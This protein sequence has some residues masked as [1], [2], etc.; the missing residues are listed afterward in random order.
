M[1]KENH[2]QEL[3]SKHGQGVIDPEHIES[4]LSRLGKGP[5]SRI[6][7]E[8]SGLGLSY[9]QKR[10]TK[11]EKKISEKQSLRYDEIQWYRQEALKK[12]EKAQ[13][14]ESDKSRRDKEIWESDQML[15]RL[16][17]PLIEIGFANSEQSATRII[18]MI[19]DS[20]FYQ[21]TIQ[22]FRLF[23]KLLVK[24]TVW[25]EIQRIIFAV[26]RDKNDRHAVSSPSVLFST[27]IS[28]V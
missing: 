11:I 4:E 14:H 18:L 5:F 13:K 26:F 17:Y 23:F 10:C 24:R 20:Y 28:P 1:R 2:F 25:F 16:V 19:R 22:V 15:E 6:K 9:T 21:R 8:I 3:I 7:D 12:R 27:V